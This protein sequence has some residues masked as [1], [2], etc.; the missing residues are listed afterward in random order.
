[1]NKNNRSLLRKE[2]RAARRSLRPAQQ[3]AAGQQLM[4]QLRNWLPLIRSRHIAFYLPNDGEID[5]R[6]LLRCMEQ[7]GKCCYL[8]CLFA[9]GQNRVRFLRNR[10]FEKCCNCYPP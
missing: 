8:P 4:R 3:R 5:P 9:D 7:R 6:P 2:L 10:G 1:M